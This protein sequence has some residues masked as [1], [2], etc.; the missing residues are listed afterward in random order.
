MESY[1][2][3]HHSHKLDFERLTTNPIQ[4]LPGTME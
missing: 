2:M 1:K 4:T 3:L